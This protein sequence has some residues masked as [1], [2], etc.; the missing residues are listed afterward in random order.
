M[1]IMN[2]TEYCSY[3]L[4]C[5]SKRPRLISTDKVMNNKRK[6][7]WIDLSFEEVEKIPMTNGR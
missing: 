4:L 7:E 2:N 5:V 3:Q 1:K 6:I